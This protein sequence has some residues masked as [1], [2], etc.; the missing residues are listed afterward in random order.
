MSCWPG[1]KNLVDKS[2]STGGSDTRRFSLRSK[3]GVG[4]G[5]GQEGQGYQAWEPLD[6][7]AAHRLHSARGHCPGVV[8]EH[9]KVAVEPH[10]CLYPCRIQRCGN[11]FWHSS[12]YAFQTVQLREVGSDLRVVITLT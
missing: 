6:C 3:V 10:Y 8:R 9:H 12:G 2:S 4:L 1:G 5:E 7:R 11:L